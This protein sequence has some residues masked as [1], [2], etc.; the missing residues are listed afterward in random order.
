MTAGDK[1]SFLAIFTEGL[2]SFLS[3]CVL[4]LIPLYISYLTA[5][6]RTVNEE[7]ETEYKRGKVLLITLCFILGISLTFLILGFSASKIGSLL[8]RYNEILG[9]FGGLLLVFFAL[10]Q[11][12]VIRIPFLEKTGRLPFDPGEGMSLFK[13]FLMGFVF[14]FAWT[15]CVGPMLSNALILMAGDPVN[16]YRYLLFYALGFLLPFLFLGLFTQLGLKLI[17]RHK[18]IMKY[19]LRIAAVILMA[20]GLWMTYQNTSKIIRIKSELDRERQQQSAS[21][22]AFGETEIKDHLGNT[23]K[24]ADYEGDLIFL[25]FTTTWC[26]YCRQEI[27]HYQEFLKKHDLRG[28]YIMN[29][30]AN[31]VPES[32][33]AEYA[34]KNGV[35]IPILIDSD[36][37]FFSYFQ[38]SGYPTL[39]VIDENGTV[40][41]YISGM[42]DEQNFEDLLANIRSQ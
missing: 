14:S 31:G 32:A 39:F 29:N 6:A 19:T 33:I 1:L 18:G 27:P 30:T 13:A 12:E 22:F 2:L 28:F 40:L 5:D 9:L 25:N 34:E 4:P 11:L 7:G 10:V 37:R 21:A 20:F 17:N 38:I 42:L 23:H 8:S 36:D 15:P 41:G 3:P 24:L 26:T 16:G 35:E